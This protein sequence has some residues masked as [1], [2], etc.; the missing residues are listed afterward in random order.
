MDWNNAEVLGSYSVPCWAL[1]HSFHSY[2]LT[3]FLQIWPPLLLYSADWRNVRWSGS[4][5]SAVQMNVICLVWVRLIPRII[6]VSVA[7]FMALSTL[8]NFENSPE[9][10]FVFSLCSSGLISALLVLSTICLFMKVSFSPDIIRS[11]W[12]GSKHQI[13]NQLASLVKVNHYLF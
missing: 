8:F 10:L 7:V 13:T 6:S 5:S 1:H 4:E 2:V 3:S 12:P 11:G 9:N